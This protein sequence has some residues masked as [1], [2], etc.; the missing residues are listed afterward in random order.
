METW[1]WGFC[2]L[3][4][5]CRLLWKISQWHIV[6]D[7]ECRE[8]FCNFKIAKL[9]NTTQQAITKRCLRLY[10]YSRKTWIN[11]AKVWY[12]I[13]DTLDIEIAGDCIVNWDSIQCIL[14]IGRE[15]DGKL[16]DNRCA[17]V[18]WLTSS[19]LSWRTQKKDHLH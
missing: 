13:Y 8:I 2:L 18:I 9:R 4:V 16:T 14:H 7:I 3:F 19:C 12:V 5:L 11:K 15:R 1:R 10:I 6:Q 17:C